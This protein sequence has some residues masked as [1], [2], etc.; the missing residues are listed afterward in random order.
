MFGVRFMFK[1]AVCDDMPLHTKILIKLLKTYKEERTGLLFETHVYHSPDDLLKDV[2]KGKKFSIFLLDIIM[3]DTDGIEL[4]RQIRETDE[5]VPLVFVTQ[6]DEHALDAFGVSAVQYIVKPIKKDA[7]FSSLDKIF[8]YLDHRSD[9][10]TTVSSLGRVMTLL[11]SSVVVVENAGRVLRYHLV[12]GEYVD[13]KAIRTTF[14]AALSD[15]LQDKRF[16]F[17]HQSYVINMEHVKELHGRRFRMINGMEVSIPRPRFSATRKI[18][19]DFLSGAA[20]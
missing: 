3:Q 1:I 10:F 2:A 7:L 13:S 17:V 6:S 9:S 12:S 4:A 14:S 8:A 11:R 5:N 18:Y 19:L 16:L 20:R 15:L